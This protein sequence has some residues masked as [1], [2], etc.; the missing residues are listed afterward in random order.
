MKA[1]SV[2]QPWASLISEG[3][4]TVE[5]R[6]WK[7]NYRG[8]LLI[9]SSARQDDSFE[10]FDEVT[11]P[12]GVAL[13]VVELEEIVQ[14]T[15]DHAMSAYPLENMQQEREDVPDGQYAWILKTPLM[16]EAPFPVKGKLNLFEVELP[17][18]IKLVPAEEYFIQ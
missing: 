2:R 14:M 3:A 6:S 15:R 8:P 1:I 4:K 10:K 16:L 13:C 9:C 17:P 11:C 7:T 18:E 5:V 12:L